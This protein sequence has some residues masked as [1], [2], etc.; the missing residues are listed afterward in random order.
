M[1][2]THRTYLRLEQTERSVLVPTLWR[3]NI[4]IRPHQILR[5]LFGILHRTTHLPLH[6]IKCT[7]N[8]LGKS[9]SN[10]RYATI[11]NLACFALTHMRG[12]PI[13]LISGGH[14]QEFESR[15]T[16]QLVTY[17][18]QRTHDVFKLCKI[19]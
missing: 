10:H 16:S 18:C 14:R 11:T 9:S 12:V 15:L 19:Q 5:R 4:V 8:C 2:Q 7:L 3:E 17:D 1:V 6:Q 13:N